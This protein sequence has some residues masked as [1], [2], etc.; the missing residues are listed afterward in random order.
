M[1]CLF[2][3]KKIIV[4]IRLKYKKIPKIVAQK[5]RK[6]RTGSKKAKNAVIT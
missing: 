5:Q 6:T 4:W 1:C 2:I 3:L